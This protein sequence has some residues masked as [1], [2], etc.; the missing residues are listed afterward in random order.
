[1]CV[2]VCR[3]RPA[4]AFLPDSRETQDSSDGSSRLPPVTN[5][6]L[7]TGNARDVS[8]TAALRLPNTSTDSDPNVKSSF[9]AKSKF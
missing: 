4:S 7:E 6:H 2:C 5:L 8:V 1:M 3:S 9:V